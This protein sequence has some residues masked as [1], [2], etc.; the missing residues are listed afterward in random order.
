MGALG[1][2]VKPA[3]E[4]GGGRWEG[5]VCP[6]GPIH[7]KWVECDHS[8][9]RL[10]RPDQITHGRSAGR[11]PPPSTRTPWAQ[12]DIWGHIPGQANDPR[13]D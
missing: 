9:P 6:G 12:K 4:V 13:D 3:W 10:G 1:G 5:P 2:G 7:P 8:E 11:R